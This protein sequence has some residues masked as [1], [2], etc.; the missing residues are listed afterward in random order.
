MSTLTS[1]KN[2]LQPTG[3]KIIIN[4]DNYS[5]LEYFAQA[6][7]H[8]GASVNPTELPVKRVTS[9]PLAGDKINYGEMSIDVLL[10]EDMESYKEMQ[11]WLE[12]IVNDGQVN[13]LPGDGRTSTYAD[14]AILILSSH[15]NKNVQIKY[16]DCVPTNLGSIQ[17]ASNTGDLTYPT[18]SA[19]FR[20]SHFEIS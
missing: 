5:N 20:F 10:D 6:I 3:F 16:Y 9:V 19:S 12:R 17:L 13:A 4:R 18:Y 8:P 14:I 7:T 2:Y 11:A 1:N 15:N